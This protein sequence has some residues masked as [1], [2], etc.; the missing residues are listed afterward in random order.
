[1]HK[2]LHIHY[3]ILIAALKEVLYYDAPIIG[4]EMRPRD[5]RDDLPKVSVNK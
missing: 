2:T 3:L 1:M 5:V 4:E